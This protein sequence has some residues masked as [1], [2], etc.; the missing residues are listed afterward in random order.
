MIAG[1]LIS[2]SDIFNLLRWPPDIFLLSEC[3]LHI[4]DIIQA[5]AVQHL[6][7]LAGYCFIIEISKQSL[8]L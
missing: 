1:S 4:L 6:I 5:E 3:H 8:A 7:H 2:S